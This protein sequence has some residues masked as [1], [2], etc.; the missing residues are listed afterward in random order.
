MSH[1]WHILYGEDRITCEKS[2]EYQVFGWTQCFDFT[3]NNLVNTYELTL[4][5]ENVILTILAFYTIRQI[6]T[7]KKEPRVIIVYILLSVHLILGILL[8][9]SPP[10]WLEEGFTKIYDWSGLMLTAFALFTLELL[11]E[12]KDINTYDTF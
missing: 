9:L 8:L 3:W 1:L 4:P 11:I 5:I 6:F 12:T 2:N 7:L 10:I